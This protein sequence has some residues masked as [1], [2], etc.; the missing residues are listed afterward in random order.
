MAPDSNARN[1]AALLI[2]RKDSTL[3]IRPF[4]DSWHIAQR[5]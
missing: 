4:G 1:I 3:G 2:L 5:F